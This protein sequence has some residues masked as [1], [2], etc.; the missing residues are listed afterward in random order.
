MENIQTTYHQLSQKLEDIK[1]K[2]SR[3]KE[4]KECNQLLTSLDAKRES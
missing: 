2:I 1:T 3:A 4:L